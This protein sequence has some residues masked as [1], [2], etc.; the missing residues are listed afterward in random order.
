MLDPSWSHAQRIMGWTR[1]LAGGLSRTSAMRDRRSSGGAPE[2]VTP[3]IP[4]NGSGRI[5]RGWWHTPPEKPG[6]QPTGKT[7]RGAGKSG[8]DRQG[9]K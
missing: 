5:S 2:A 7:Q 8:T 6:F 4:E 1:G 3:E 9:E